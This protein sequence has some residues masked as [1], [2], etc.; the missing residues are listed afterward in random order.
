MYII[1]FINLYIYMS[2]FNKSNMNNNKSMYNKQIKQ[3][4]NIIKLHNKSNKKINAKHSKR[5]FSF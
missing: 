5:N 4:I 2:L 3:K 1:N